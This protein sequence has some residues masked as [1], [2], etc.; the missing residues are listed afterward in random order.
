MTKNP[1]RYL[2]LIVRKF[3][4]RTVGY[5]DYGGVILYENPDNR[6][7]LFHSIRGKSAYKSPR[8][9]HKQF[10]LKCDPERQLKY[11]GPAIKDILETLEVMGVQHQP[12]S[13]IRPL[14]VQYNAYYSDRHA[15]SI[16]VL[17]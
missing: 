9:G 10:G 3:I 5:A 4:E 13:T 7:R 12:K 1:S 16:F 14:H 6:H 15:G 2:S 11:P 17:K 8:I